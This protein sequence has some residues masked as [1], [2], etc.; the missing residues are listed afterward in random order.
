MEAYQASAG[1]SA[2][3]SRAAAVSTDAVVTHPCS[4]TLLPLK[5]ANQPGNQPQLA[6][7]QTAADSYS[8]LKGARAN[9]SIGQGNTPTAVQA[10]LHQLSAARSIA[11]G[12]LSD[13]RSAAG[14][15][16]TAV[17]RCAQLLPASCMQAAVMLQFVL[18][19]QLNIYS[20]MLV[21]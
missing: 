10:Y 9:A 12:L 4:F 17:N 20:S 19:L 16:Q 21:A 14:A 3:S 13:P 5:A 18:Q 8:P 15:V 2:S 1:G 6:Q 7:Q 11:M